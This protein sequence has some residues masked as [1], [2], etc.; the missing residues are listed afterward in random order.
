MRTFE[1]QITRFYSIKPDEQN[2][3]HE[4]INVILDLEDLTDARVLPF[5]L[6]R[7]VD[8]N[9]YD[10][11]RIEIIKIF[12]VRENQTNEFELIANA[13]QRILQQEDDSLVKQWAAQES[14]RYIENNSLFKALLRV[15]VDD[16]EYVGVRHNALCVIQEKGKNAD[17]IKAL[18][19][20]ID[21]PE[22]ENYDIS[23]INAVKS[24]L[25]D[26][27]K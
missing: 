15:V 11:A 21:D 26:F 4:K 25:D 8:I 18:E 17:S 3:E 16:D 2:E 13:I 7:V 27:R 24:L 6:N 22:D 14:S 10:L 19:S 12:A 23:F 5:F 9:E 20:V 1:E